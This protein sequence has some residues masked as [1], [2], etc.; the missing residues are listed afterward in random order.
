MRRLIWAVV[1]LTIG[2]MV[3]GCGKVSKKEGGPGTTA[4]GEKGKEGG[5][6]AVARVGKR[7]ITIG[8]LQAQIERAHPLFRAQFESKEGK[9]QLLDRMV[10]VE[11]LYQE[12]LKQG[13]DKDPEYISHLEEGKKMLLANMLQKKIADTEV[14]ISD[15]DL[16]KYY[17]EHKENYFTPPTAQIYLTLVKVAK[18]ATPAD[19]NKAKATIDKAYKD[20]KAGKDFGDVAKNYS[21]D[22][23]S[24]KRGGEIPKLRKGSRSEEFDKVVFE[25]LKPNEFS[26]PFLDNRGWNI[27]KLVSKTEASYRPLEEVKSQIESTLQNEKKKEAMD[28][29]IEDLKTKYGVVIYEDQLGG[30]EEEKPAAPQGELEEIPMKRPAEQQPPQQQQQQQPPAGGGK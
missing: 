13:I 17:E 11:L 10:H 7:T 18:D 26:K 28:K 27:V 23:F 25:Q 30:K 5:G 14:K 16:T 15:E 20:L 3:V 24:A 21:E 1:V 4:Y 9:K 8:D 29:Y 2:L 12:A 22:T 19:Q 6:P